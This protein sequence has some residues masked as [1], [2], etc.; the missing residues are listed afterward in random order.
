MSDYLY[1]LQPGW[2]STATLTGN[3]ANNIENWVAGASAGFGKRP[4][5]YWHV[6]DK[7]LTTR[8]RR[9]QTVQTLGR[10]QRQHGDFFF[11]WGWK[12]MPE[13][14]IAYML[15]YAGFSSGYKLYDETEQSVQVS[16]YHLM[17][18]Q[19]NGTPA[20]AFNLPFGL[21]KAFN[22]WMHRPIAGQDYKACYGGAENI[23]FRF[24]GGSVAS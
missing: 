23:I 24:S 3:T 2:V 7:E 15:Q 18:G 16:V 17:Y 6:P 14:A 4:D 10:K 1:M 22:C 11:Q 9:P 12:F 8:A 13:N 21:Y 5:W 20:Y 19:W